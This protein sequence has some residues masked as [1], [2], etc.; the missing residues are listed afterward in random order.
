MPFRKAQLGCVDPYTKCILAPVIVRKFFFRVLRSTYGARVVR[1]LKIQF[2]SLDFHGAPPHTASCGC[3]RADN[4]RCILGMVVYHMHRAF[5][6]DKPLAIV[7]LQVPGGDGTE[8]GARDLQSFLAGCS[9]ATLSIVYAV[10]WAVM[11]WNSTC[12]YHRLSV[13]FIYRR[14]SFYDK[15]SSDLLYLNELYITR[16]CVQFLLASW[17]YL[18]WILSCCSNWYRELREE[19]SL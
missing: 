3:Q 16:W 5:R 12:I 11:S 14:V 19:G 9:H 18:G 10:V 2:R 7:E 8:I 15:P 13:G 4:A 17:S 1:R 6:R